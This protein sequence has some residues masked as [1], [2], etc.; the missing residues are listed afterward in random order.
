MRWA[1]WLTQTSRAEGERLIGVHV[2]E[3]DHLRVAL[4][5]HHLQEVLDAARGA[6]DAQLESSQV[7]S[8]FEAVHVQQ[9]GRAEEALA[10]SVAYHHADVLVIGRQA[11]KDGHGIT[12][13]GRVARRLL[14]IL[15][16]PTIVVPPD[17]APPR[18]EAAPI[19]VACNLEDDCHHALTFAVDLAAR[20]DRPLVVVHVVSIPDDYG[21]RI[22][23]EASLDALRIDNQR[24]GEALLSRW[25]RDRGVDATCLVMQGEVV[26]SLLEVAR[27]RDAALLVL[28]SRR[29][30]TLERVFLT[31]SGSET[32]SLAP[33]AVA[34]VPPV[35][36]AA[37]T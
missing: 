26:E 11:A 5:Y 20:S 32:A 28:G 3:D 27:Q 22:L 25:V 21:A 33:C 2:V 34:I 6:V 16:V 1:A 15:P 23:S 7:Q 4:R 14:R 18:D 35:V 9:G 13:L 10:V 19:V 24:E 37:A 12:R 30:S 17:L 8:R 31:S 36:D 29:L